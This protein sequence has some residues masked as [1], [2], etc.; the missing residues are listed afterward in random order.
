MNHIGHIL[1]VKLLLEAYKSKALHKMTVIVFSPPNL[2]VTA[3]IKSM[4]HY[5]QTYRVHVGRYRC[6]QQGLLSVPAL[7]NKPFP[8]TGSFPKLPHSFGRTANEKD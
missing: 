3:Y 2:N 6:S 1:K 7:D 4:Y 8:H 5:M